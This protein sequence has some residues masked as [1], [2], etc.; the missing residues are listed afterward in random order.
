M[1]SDPKNNIMRLGLT[2]GMLVADF[3]TGSGHYAIEA[4]RIVGNSGRVYAIDIQQAL[5]KKV[6]NLA[7][8][9]NRQNI[10]VL[11]GDIEQI[12][13]TKLGDESVDA[14]IIANDLFQVEEKNNV[15]IEARRILK[16]KGKVLVVDWLDSFAGIGPSGDVIVRESEAR[17]LL[18]ENGFEFVQ[19][20]D[21]GEHHYGLIFIKS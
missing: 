3:G 12:R 13:G 21:A 17:K 15:I 20:F 10:D 6:K 8:A 9:E 19:D 7:L 5:V 18:S 2:D 4:S 14:V 11:W 16:P 1:F